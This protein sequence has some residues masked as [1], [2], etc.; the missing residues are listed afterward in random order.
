MMVPANSLLSQMLILGG[1]TTDRKSTSGNIITCGTKPIYWS[2][3]K[4][5][6][7]ALS[8]AEAEYISTTECV[9]K[10][11]YIRNLLIETL[12]IKKPI[13]IYTDNQASKKI[14]ENGEINN[15]LKHLDIKLHFNFDNIKN[16]KI[17]LEYICSEEMLAD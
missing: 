11:L 13:T 5:P 9:R 16:N 7:V 8:T 3:K 4:Q 10:A 14:I 6:T 17:K 2:S 1:D 15:K 12:N